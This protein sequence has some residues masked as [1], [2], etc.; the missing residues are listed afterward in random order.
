MIDLKMTNAG[1]YMNKQVN[2]DNVID[3]LHELGLDGLKERYGIKH[4]QNP[5]FPNLYVLN[6]DQIESSKVKDH[7]VVKQCRSLVV[8]YDDLSWRIESHSFDRFFNHG[9]VQNQPDVTECHAYEKVDG[10]LVSVWFN[11]DSQKWLYRTKSMIMPG[12]DAQMIS[13]RKWKELIESVIIGPFD[14]KDCTY[15][16]EVV[17]RDNRVVTRYDD[18]G[19][20]LLAVRNNKTGDYFNNSNV[21]DVYSKMSRISSKVYLPKRYDFDTIDHCLVAVKELPN[22]EEGYVMYNYYNEPVMKVKSPAYVAAHRL[23]G[24]S[25][26]T[27][28]RIFEMIR[29][30]EDEE[31]LTIFPEDSEAFG[32]ATEQ[33]EARIYEMYTCWYDRLQ[34]IKDQKEFALEVM[35]LCPQYQGFMFQ[36]KNKPE[37]SFSDMAYEL[38]I[39]KFLQI[40]GFKE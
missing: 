37:L 23:R 30:G 8:R 38:H 6:Y 14:D 40:F 39:N 15:I 1:D 4:S 9:E 18:D 7:P 22:L 33:Y 32:K 17:S 16:F 31:Y 25:V 2:F 26:L 35:K 28:K 27:P 11:K 19:A 21:K 3:A 10:S 34:Y 13:G 36:K 29:I 24:E 5:D 20:Y 12:D